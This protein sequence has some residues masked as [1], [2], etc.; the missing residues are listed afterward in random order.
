MDFQRSALD[1]IDDLRAGKT[2]PTQLAEE[3][4]DRIESIDAT[5]YELNSILALAPKFDGK[6]FSLDSPLAGL[7]I[8]IKDNIEAVGLPGTAGSTALLDHRVIDDSELVKRL[9]AA[10]ANII[11]S[12]NLS[13]WANIRSTSSTSGWSAVGGLTANPWI[14]QHSAGGSSS[15]SG[16]AIAGGLV[17]LAVGTETDGSIICP[18]SLNGCVGIKPTVGTVSTQGV[19]PIS[20]NQDSPGPM[21]R[22]VKDAALLL[23][24][25]SATSGLVKGAEDNRRLRIGIVR[26]WLTGHSE[27]DALFDGA[28]SKLSKTGATLVEVDLKPPSDD[29]GNDEYEVLLHELFDEMGAYLTVRADTS[30]KSLADIVAY[31]L[32]HKESELKFFAQELFDKALKLGGR[33]SAYQAK[34]ARNLAWAQKTLDKGLSQVDVLIGATYS[35]AWLSTLGKGDD[36]G[37]NSWITM[38]PAIAGTPIGALPMGICQGLPVGLGVVAKANDE[39]NLVT[40]MA[41]IERALDIGVLTPSFKK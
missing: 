34:R 31:N 2:T 26:S 17:T 38:A 11:A 35:P 24:I 16:A 37:D 19:I 32:A 30:L 22:S 14:H 10:G 5:G 4:L 9:R 18:A 33:N 20:A 12:T 8:V 21:A 6:S 25:M 39:V 41:Q 3:A 13:E 15:G 7:P 36:Y 23:E 27:T 40:A 29:V 1:S 28:I